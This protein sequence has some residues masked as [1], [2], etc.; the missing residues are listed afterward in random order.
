MTEFLEKA[1]YKQTKIPTKSTEVIK[2]LYKI[3]NSPTFG[4]HMIAIEDIPAGTI[5]MRKQPLILG[6]K[7]A[8]EPI[9]LGC[10]EKLDFLYEDCSKCGWPLCSQECENSDM[11]RIE[12]ETLSQSGYKPNIELDQER[13][14][15]Y[16]AIAPLRCFLMKKSNPVVYEELMSFQSH[17]EE[18]M[19]FLVYHILKKRLLP[20]FNDKLN[21][22]I[23]ENELLTLCSIL[24]TNTFDVRDAKGKINIRGLYTTA[25]L[26][27]HQCKH[28]TKHSFQG[29][30][31]ELLLTT[32]VPIK[33]GE[34]ISATYTQ[35]LW[36]TMNRRL[37]LKRFKHFDCICTRCSDPTEFGTYAGSIYCSQCRVCDK[38]KSCPKMISTNPLDNNAQWQCEKCDYIISGRQMLWNNEAMKIAIRDLEKYPWE[39]E[40]F[41]EIYENV[42]HPTNCHAL[43]VKYALVQMYEDM[44]GCILV[45]KNILRISISFF[46]VAEI[47]DDDLE[48]KIELCQELL[49]VADILEPGLSKFRGL[50]LY[51]LQ[52]AMV[53]QAKRRYENEEMSREDVE[54]MFKEFVLIM[55]AQCKIFFFLESNG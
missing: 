32:T 35:T 50:L 12:C 22:V 47:S 39:F 14:V 55:S 10:H 21:I 15:V 25:N 38:S 52:E 33:E 16:T 17:L 36:G 34:I 40:R 45:T 27:T 31:F 41:L 53:V 42:L 37:H 49:D 44:E 46:F 30:N 3:E 11:H 7:L 23:T 9:C 5:I 29:K 4:R 19:K 20:F 28:N 48:R 6:P 26:L 18:N 43:D 13:Q 24:D 8:S 54:V 1:V 2:K 51:D